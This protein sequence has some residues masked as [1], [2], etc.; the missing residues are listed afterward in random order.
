MRPPKVD[1]RKLR[2][3]NL[4]TPEFRHLYLLLG[5]VSYF[6]LYA[7]TENCIPEEACHLIHVPLDDRIP[8]REEFVIF[9]VGWY[10]LL[11]GSLCYFLFYDVKAFRQLQTYLI[12]TQ[13]IAM[14][15]YIFYPSRQDL[16][17]DVFP[18][19]NIF[20]A[21]LGILYRIDTPTGI[22]PSLHVAYS[23]GIASTWL[24]KQD[25]KPWLKT[26]IVIF[27]LGV[28]ASVSFVKQHSV[29]DIAAAIP[30]C[31]VAEWLVFFRLLHS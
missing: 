5:W 20:T 15:I 29:V 18:R 30:L 10:L 13:S 6:I 16:R 7:L 1:Y 27:C 12:I 28:C 11:A 26:A 19:E 25:A 23:L 9:Y 8:F 21:I 14:V 17:P 31:L 22:C 4:N 2:L 24:R 3:H